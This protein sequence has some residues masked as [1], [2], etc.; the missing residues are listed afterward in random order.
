MPHWKSIESPRKRGRPLTYEE[1]WM[2]YYAFQSFERH[3]AENSVIVVEDPYAVTGSYVGVSR[4]TVANIVKSVRDSGRVPQ[5]TSPG[6]RNQKTARSLFQQKQ[7]FENVCVIGIVKEPYV[8]R[9]MLSHYSKRNFIW[10]FRIE[11][12]DAIL[13]VWACV[14]HARHNRRDRDEKAVEFVNNDMIICMRY[15]QIGG[16]PL[17]SSIT[18][19]I[20]MNVSFITILV[21]NFH[22]FQMEIL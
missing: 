20:W 22:G 19:S 18:S 6:H 7:E 14:G 1:K 2:V 15:E 16:C 21:L 12:C 5:F 10:T 9:N 13:L 8:T 17:T 4:T 3:K 11:L